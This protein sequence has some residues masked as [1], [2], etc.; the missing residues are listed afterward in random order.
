MLKSEN[1]KKPIKRRSPARGFNRDAMM[2]LQATTLL[3]S[4]Y[5]RVSLQNFSK[6]FVRLEPP[7]VKYPIQRPL[8]GIKPVLNYPIKSEESGHYAVIESS[9]KA[10]RT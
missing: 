4:T 8:H 3:T 6:C 5:P 9:E 2:L 10:G 7:L 1:E